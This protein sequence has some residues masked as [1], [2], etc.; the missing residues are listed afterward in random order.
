[1]NRRQF[2]QQSAFSASALWVSAR[3]FPQGKS[4]NEKLNI[5]IIGAG[6][7][8]GDNLAGVKGENI[9]A[10]CDVDDTILNAAAQQFP[11]AKTYNDYRKLL[12][13]KD[14]DA[15]V[16]STPDHT[17]AVATL[18]ALDS[19]HHVY[20]EKPLTHTI[21]EARKVMEMAR[22]KKRVTQ[23]GTQIHAGSNYRRV[24]ELIQTGVIG[25]ITEIH[26]FVG[27][28]WSAEGRPAE[29][30]PVPATLHWDQWLGPAA[31]RPYSPAYFGMK[32]RCYWEFGGGALADMAC[33]HMDLSHWALNLKYP[34]TVEAEGPTINSEG[35]PPWLKVHYTYEREKG[36][37]PIKLTWYNGD[38]RPP[39]FAEGKLPEWGDGSLFIGTKGMLLADYGRY[40]LLPEKDFEGFQPPPPFFA[41]SPGHHA[42]WIDAC[43]RGGMT[44]CHFGYGGALT[45]T[46]LLG[47][48]A[49]RSGKKLEWDG[50]KGRIT[51]TKEANQYLQTSYRKGW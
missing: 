36:K 35:A 28:V 33:H 20:C 29:T 6:G 47:N 50:E 26:V 34:A 1:M 21:S 46:V 30:P 15:I 5:G 24:V 43:K 48:V 18:A 9:V 38:K 3:A 14:I 32:W 23:M 41:E 16:I 31:E 39:H 12:E 4:P 44:T 42:E 2:L 17:H 49:Y 37:P 11:Q 10:L 45:Q 51:N 27:S 40:K 25:E 22:K 13:Q 7:R 8:G 19:G